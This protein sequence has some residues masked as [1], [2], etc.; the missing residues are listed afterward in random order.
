MCLALPGTSE[1]LSHGEPTFFVQGKVFVMFADNHHGD[2]RIAVWLPVPPGA[3]AAHLAGAPGA[4]FKPPYVGVRGWVGIELDAIDDEGLRDRIQVAWELTAPGRLLSNVTRPPVGIGQGQRADADVP[5][6][7][8]P[9]KRALAAAG[10]T[11][12]AQ[13]SRFSEAEVRAWHSI[14]P[15]ALNALRQA[16]AASGLSFAPDRS[17]TSAD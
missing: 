4:Y 15:N 3:Q 2:G 1:R 13:L 16:M 9:A 7:A 12:L 14:G 6:L 8:A 17:R 5:R 11:S 10:V